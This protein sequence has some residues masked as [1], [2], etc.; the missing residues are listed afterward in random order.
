MYSTDQDYNQDSRAIVWKVN[1]YI[2]GEASDPVTVTRSDFLIDASVLEEASASSDSLIGNITANELSLTLLNED[3]LFTPTNAQSKYYGKMVKGVKLEVFCTPLLMSDEDIETLDDEAWDPLGVF[4][5]SEWTAAVNSL[6]ASI[7]AYDSIER[8]INENAPQLPIAYNVLHTDFIKQIL[9]SIMY[10]VSVDTCSDKPISFAYVGD[11]TKDTLNDICAASLYNLFCNHTG[12]IVYSNLMKQRLL[13]AVLTDENQIISVDAESTINA[14]YDGVS[15]SYKNTQVSNVIELLNIK[16]VQAPVGVSQL[17]EATLSS[18]PMIALSHA[19]VTG[20]DHVHV[21]GVNGTLRTAA[22]SLTNITENNKKVSVSLFGRVL[23][24]SESTTGIS[25][26]DP[27]SVSS[28]YI[29]SAEQAKGVVDKLS[30]FTRG[31]MPCITAVIR[32]NAKLQIGDKIRLSST[33]YNL[34]YTGI[35]IRQEYK[36]T[37]SMTCTITLVSAAILGGD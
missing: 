37:G 10:D 32:G 13:R 29:Q 25:G 34:D 23:E 7:T 9:N 31:T 11:S 1:M 20:D 35:I 17:A 5:V 15:V 28:P 14:T 18:Q 6:T 30:R 33:Q 21:S 22:L 19:L 2:N 12:D 8:V 3:R 27:I 16:D 26:T 4:Y 24:S 36:Y